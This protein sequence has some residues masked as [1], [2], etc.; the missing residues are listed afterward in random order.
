M[1]QAWEAG[2]AAWPTVKL[3]RDTFD[4]YVASFDPTALERFPADLYLAAACLDH[5]PEALSCFD[6]DILTAGRGPIVS[7]NPS[8]DFVDEAMQRLRASLLVGDGSPRLTRYAGRGPLRAWVGVTAARTALQMRRSQKRA[9]ELVGDEDDWTHA[10][11]SVTTNNPELEL[12][13][14]QYASAFT[15]A[16]RDSVHMLEPRLRSVLRMSFVEALSI[17]EIAAV[18]SVHRAT[19]ARWIHRA[20]E[21]LF[22]ETRRL[23]KERLA[24]T[25]TELDRMTQ[26]IQS[27][28]DVSLSQLLPSDLPI[29]AIE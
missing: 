27:Q 12:L 2:A 10:L 23:L 6:R 26:L 3:S 7:I 4:T 19:T 20:C 29:D 28:L 18:Y 8:A 13:K 9:K 16:L 15:S 11:A 25:S 24:L 17:D 14:K 21:A 5:N 1:T 22:G